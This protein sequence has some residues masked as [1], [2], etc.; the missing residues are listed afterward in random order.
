MIED[1]DLGA[2]AFAF[3][4]DAC[5]L[6]VMSHL[7][8][9]LQRQIAPLGLSAAASG[10]V[11]GPKA[12]SSNPFHFTN[13]PDA[14]AAHYSAEDL[15]L[16]DPSVR[17][18]RSSGRALTWSD[19]FNLLPVRDPGRKVIEAAALF[20]YTEG[21]VVPMRSRDNSLGL[22]C[23][24]GKRDPLSQ[25]EQVFLTIVAR[26]AFE[27]AERIENAGDIGRPAP[28]LTAREIECLALLVR[29]HSDQAIGKVLGLSLPTIRFHLG[30]ARDK[31]AATSRAHLAAIAIRQGFVTL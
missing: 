4:S 14:W 24:G 25:K 2:R 5:S 22:V 19:L 1:A 9:A 15:V 17:W 3:A 20:G 12:A 29:G 16:L 7:A 13:W 21:M 30:N 6:K 31:C 27:A 10:F 28:V 11:S 18:A 26:A 23:F 8:T